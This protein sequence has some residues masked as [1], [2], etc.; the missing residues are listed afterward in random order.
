MN[1][2]DF[3]AEIEKLISLA[4]GGTLSPAEQEA[5]LNSKKF[6]DTA[7]II[8]SL[9]IEFK[10]FILTQVEGSSPGMLICVYLTVLGEM[11][12]LSGLTKDSSIPGKLF[13]KGYEYGESRQLKTQQQ[14][15][16]K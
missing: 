5:Y 9:Q 4:E 1:K 2:K 13:A 11:A 16:E 15:T 6:E 3:N 12:A 7:E 8:N 14:E 10:K